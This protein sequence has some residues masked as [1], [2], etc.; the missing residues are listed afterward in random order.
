METL[1]RV[2][3]EQPFFHGL[4]AAFIKLA[5]GCAKMF[6]SKLEIRSAAKAT[7]S[8]SSTLCGKA[9]WRSSSSLPVGAQ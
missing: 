9:A 6:D 8:T 4:D 7:A 2:L 3:G 1:E 5:C